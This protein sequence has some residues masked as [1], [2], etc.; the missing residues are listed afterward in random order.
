MEKDW[1]TSFPE[2]WIWLQCNNFS[3]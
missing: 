3:K 2:A 1:G